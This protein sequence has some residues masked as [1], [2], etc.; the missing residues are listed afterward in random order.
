MWP[1]RAIPPPG[2][3]LFYGE[4]LINAQGEDVVAGI[5]TPQP[6]TR[7]QAEGT[8]LKSLEEVMPEAFAELDATCKRL[9]T[10]FKD[11]QDIEFTIERG[12]LFLL[13]T[14]IGKRTAMAGI[15]IA[16]D[17]VDEGL[18]DSQHR[19]EAHRRRQPVPAP[20][21]GLRP[22]GEGPAAQGGAAPHQGT[23]RRSGRGHGSHRPD[24]RGC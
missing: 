9:E 11:M 14:R 16:I 20:G 5:R 22:E 1:S 21:P 3:K 13:Q 19:T 10:H 4:Y 24:G 18:I 8:G 2:E 7:R 17:L 15:R 12:K 6:I 23:E